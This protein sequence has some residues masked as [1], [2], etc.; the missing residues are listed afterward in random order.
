L[1]RGLPSGQ[2][3][4]EEGEVVEAAAAMGSEQPRLTVGPGG[5]LVDGAA[6][7]PP[8]I[9]PSDSIVSQPARALEQ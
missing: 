5:S 1:L 9:P 2:E 7:A 3:A 4:E 6:A 8:R